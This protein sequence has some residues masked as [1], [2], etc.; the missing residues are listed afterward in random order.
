MY[1]VVVC[2]LLDVVIVIN[3]R[4]TII[5]VIIAKIIAVSL[6]LRLIKSPYSLC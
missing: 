5:T 3:E 4:T 6:I 1:V 2:N